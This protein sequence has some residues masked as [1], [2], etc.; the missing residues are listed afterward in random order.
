M[1]RPRAVVTHPY[2]DTFGVEN[3]AD[4]I[5]VNA[6]DVE[7]NGGAPCFRRG[8]ADDPYAWQRP[9]RIKRVRGQH[10]L[11]PL[12]R[13]HADTGEVIAGGSQA[14]GLRGHRYA[15]LEALRW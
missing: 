12:D 5:G 4:V 15:G 2:R 7:G 11:V 8:R 1:Q 6:F 9:D 13:R 14:D 3:L 10:S